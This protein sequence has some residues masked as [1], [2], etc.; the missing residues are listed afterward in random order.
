M[1]ADDQHRYG[2]P[3]EYSMWPEQNVRTKPYHQASV[4]T[5]QTEVPT[6]LATSSVLW[7]TE[8][9]HLWQKL[10]SRNNYGSR[11]YLHH[12]DSW[13]SSSSNRPITKVSKEQ[14]RNTKA[15]HMRQLFM[16]KAPQ[17][18]SCTQ[19]TCLLIQATRKR[20]S[21][22]IKVRLYSPPSSSKG[23]GGLAWAPWIYIYIYMHTHQLAGWQAGWLAG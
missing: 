3:S 11:N 15:T 22:R 9:T 16:Q 7:S 14:A 13:W 2:R 5:L 18:A 10:S 23:V 19:T 1:C 4:W 12:Y 20:A 17:T 8:A 21:I 6:Q